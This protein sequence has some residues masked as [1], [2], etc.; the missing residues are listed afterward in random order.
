MK[1]FRGNRTPLDL[2]GKT[3]VL[4]DDGVATGYTIRAAV[5]SA[6]T[7]GAKK[8]I[9]AVPVIAQDSLKLIQEEVNEVV[10]LDAPKFFGA[11]GEFYKSFRQTTDKEVFNLL[12]N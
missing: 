6:K 2:S 7:K 9:V 5:L 3:A 1:D 8:I 4:V 11:V 12:N 10:Y